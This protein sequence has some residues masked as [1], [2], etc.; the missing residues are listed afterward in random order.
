[1]TEIVANGVQ[2]LVTGAQ[3]DIGLGPVIDEGLDLGIEERSVGHV[4]DRGRET[5]ATDL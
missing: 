1:M 4:I 2:G 3:R 5:E